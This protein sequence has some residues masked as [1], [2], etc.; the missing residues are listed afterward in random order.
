[1]FD[2]VLLPI[3][4]NHP[5]SWDKAL[6]MARKLCGAAGTLHVL[7]VMHDLGSPM[8]AS[9]LP[10]HFEEE[11]L[12]RMKADLDGFIAEQVGPGVTAVAHVEHGHVA[13]HILSAARKLGADV[14]VMASHAPDDLR[15]FFV[16][17]QADKVVRHAD[18]PVLVVR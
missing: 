6:P 16:G 2:H 17:S 13:E 8:I 11:A 5:E 10:E 15:T 9:Y 18:R 12:Q 7:G 3:D 14:I 1:M 4:L